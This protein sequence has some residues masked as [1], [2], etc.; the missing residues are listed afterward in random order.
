VEILLRNG[1]NINEKDVI[2][3]SV[4][5]TDDFEKEREKKESRDRGKESAVCVLVCGGKK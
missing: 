4:G 3:I 1:A 5:E 2:Y